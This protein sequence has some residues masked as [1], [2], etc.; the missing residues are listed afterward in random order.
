M[1]EASS[2]K[3]L[4]SVLGLAGKKVRLYVGGGE[5]GYIQGPVHKVDGDLIYI[6]KEGEIRGTLQT[7]TV[8]ATSVLY[9]EIDIVSM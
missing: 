5:R 3:F 6:E 1:N 8:H 4:E 9:F 7:I 2:S